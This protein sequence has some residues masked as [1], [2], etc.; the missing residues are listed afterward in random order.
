MSRKIIWF[1]FLTLCTAVLVYA[2]YRD[3]RVEQRF[4]GSDLRN[5]V[6]GARLIKDGRSPYF[7]KWKV[8]DGM[9]YYDPDN[10]DPDNCERGSI[11][12]ITATPFFHHLLSPIADQPQSR[13]FGIWLVLEYLALIAMILYFFRYARTPVQKAGVAG[14]ALLFLL[15]EGWYIHILYG[16]YYLFIPFLAMLFFSLLQNDK[17]WL[18]AG[19]AGLIA[20][21][22]ILIRPNFLLFFLPFL[23][24]I[25]T[26]RRNYLIAFFIPVL[27]LTAW[28]VL[29][30]KES[31]LWK[32]YKTAVAGHT[33][34][35]QHLSPFFHSADY[36]AFARWEGI[37]TVRM[38][39]PSLSDGENEH[40]NFFLLVRR[41]YKP[42][43]PLP[44]LQLL[45]LGA[46]LSLL[47][48]FLL[49]HRTA[50]G[51]SLPR[52]AL[53][54][55][56]LYMVSDFLSPIYR[57]QYYTTQWLFPLL[58]AAA[59]YDRRDKVPF[60]L[61]LTGLIL[62]IININWTSLEHSLGEYLM[63][64]AILMLS[65]GRKPAKNGLSYS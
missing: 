52:I 6:V 29:D 9:R 54:G 25:K 34:Y 30:K 35:H 60:G 45:S 28:T 63:L 16:Q 38:H 10:F 61:L 15:T 18:M 40:G 49:R 31:A 65:F 42:G 53:M 11:S 44:A 36:P 13:L 7:Y 58:L 12:V 27:L 56:S 20:I 47:A 17:N 57:W 5:R 51:Y 14:V 3:L 46:I 32:D 21:A 37:D 55:Y 22:A 64:A 24:I 50:D 8:A 62:N 1:I 59:V 19:A 4:Y 26:Y 23:A 2:L 33:A 43:L 39:P 41:I 48:A